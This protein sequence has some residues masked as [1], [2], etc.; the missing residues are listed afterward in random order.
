MHKKK[1]LSENPVIGDK[2]EI[3][4]TNTK[5]NNKYASQILDIIDENIYIISG[6]IQKSALIPLHVGSLIEITYFREDKGRFIFKARIIEREYKKIYKLKIEKI[7]CITKLQERNYYRLSVKLD[8]QKKYNLKLDDNEKEVV[9]N[10]IVKDISGGGI[11]VLC[12][13]KHSVGD[14]IK[15]QVSISDFSIIALGTVVRVHEIENNNFKFSLGI[16]FIEIEDE[17]R[18]RLIKYIFEQQRRLRKKG[19]I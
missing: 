6:P 16:K 19:L 7:S 1:T 2:I 17:D 15:L 12:N 8:V 18:E 5:T 13:F 9:E 10:C 4:E 3:R 11:R 14:L